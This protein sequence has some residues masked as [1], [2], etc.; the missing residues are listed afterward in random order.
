MRISDRMIQL[1]TMAGLRGGLARLNVAQRQAASGKRIERVSDDP[2]AAAQAMRM[3]G[4]LA[5]IDQYRRNAGSATTRLATEESVLQASRDILSRARKLAS[6]VNATAPTDPTRI[7]A[8]QELGFLKEQLVSLANTRIGDER[9]FGGGET[10]LPFQPDG[11]YVGGTSI[12]EVQVDDGVRLATSFTGAIFASSFQSLDA[13]DAAL[14]S[15]TPADISAAFSPLQ[16]AEESL[17][18]REAE[19]GARQRQIND[20]VVQLGGRSQVLLDRVQ[21]LTDVDPAESL[22]KA[23]AAQHALERAYVVAQRTL[24]LNITDYLR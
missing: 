21:A 22:L 18:A 12:H 5:A 20:S 24:S 14:R 9:L 8:L 1:S 11:T 10:A 4:Q 16:A 2:V 7:S 6:S 19:T 3:Q 15:G 23:Q 13:L 17:L